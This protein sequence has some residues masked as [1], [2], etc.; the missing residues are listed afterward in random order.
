[1]ARTFDQDAFRTSPPSGPFFPVKL[2]RDPWVKTLEHAHP[3]S[4]RSSPR[5][6]WRGRVKQCEGQ[7]S[8]SEGRNK[9]GCMD[10]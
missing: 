8:P 7:G 5:S 10:E 4:P 3:I 9:D 1:M 6:L 2:G